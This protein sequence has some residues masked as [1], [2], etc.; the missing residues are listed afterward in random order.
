MDALTKHRSVFEMF[1]YTN[2]L[3][4]GFFTLVDLG[5]IGVGIPTSTQQLVAV[6]P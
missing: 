4:L 2:K 3:T 5:L 6:R 1:N